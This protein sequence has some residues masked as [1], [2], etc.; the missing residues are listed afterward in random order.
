MIE[1]DAIIFCD[2]SPN[3]SVVKG[4]HYQFLGYAAG[5]RRLRT[6]LAMHGYNTRIVDHFSAWTEEEFENILDK[7]ISNKTKIIGISDS[8]YHAGQT[9]KMK[10]NIVIIK[11]KISKTNI[12]LVLGGNSIVSKYIGA[13][14]HFDYDAGIARDKRSSD[15][16]R[17]VSDYD[18]IISGFADRALVELMRYLDKDI[19]NINHL[20]P[21]P[22]SEIGIFDTLYIDAIDVG[23]DTQNL[24]TVWLPEDCIEPWD[25]LPIEISRGCIFN[26]SFCT[27]VLKGKR[28]FDYFRREEELIE[29]FNYNYEN[30]GTTKYTII[31]D[32]Y[33]DSKEK[34]DLMNRV[35]SRL[36]F[37]INFSAYIKPE[38][39]VT[40]GKEYQEKLIDQGLG[41]MFIG[42]E[43]LDPNTRKLYKKGAKVDKILDAV[44]YMYNYSNKKCKVVVGWILGDEPHD[45]IMD[46]Y[47]FLN[48]LPFLH[49]FVASP[50]QLYDMEKLKNDGLQD[51]TDQNFLKVISEISIDPKK[52]GL[53]IKSRSGKDPLADWNGS[54]VDSFD[55]WI[56]FDKLRRKLKIENEMKKN[57]KPFAAQDLYTKMSAIVGKYAE[58]FIEGGYSVYEFDWFAG[59]NGYDPSQIKKNKVYDAIMNDVR[60]PINIKRYIEPQPIKF[61]ET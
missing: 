18:Y 4:I 9:E 8:F 41:S 23:F 13:Y 16:W 50:L 24:R 32:T 30:F 42:L 56:V 38:L 45:K 34:I 44:E 25:G 27:Y 43:T 20:N 1:Y 33:N 5:T 37:K 35:L 48:S 29:E 60:T 57:K 19:P 14:Y 55:I 10:S 3:Q 52:F 40:F 39:L 53:N 61:L 47:S 49:T 22:Y 46:D 7:L 54:H 15:G 58:E 31:D 59:R 21:K 12:K 11:E 28:K 36:D 17:N 51:V 2:N 6:S 26:C